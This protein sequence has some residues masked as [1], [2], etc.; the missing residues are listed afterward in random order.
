MYE[1][2]RTRSEEGSVNTEFEAVTA[3]EARRIAAFANSVRT[4]FENESPMFGYN[5][6]S[7]KLLS[8]S[9][10]A[11]RETYEEDQRIK[12]ANLF[13]AFC[14]HAMVAFNASAPSRWIKSKGDI[15]IVFTRGKQQWVVFPINRVFKHIDD[16]PEYSTYE[17]FM[18]VHELLTSSTT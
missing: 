14:G 4:A 13:G 8:D 3:Q 17:F 11:R 12:V 6:P 5:P 1:L 7:V 15:G 10:T 2:T 16:G 9:I 18:A